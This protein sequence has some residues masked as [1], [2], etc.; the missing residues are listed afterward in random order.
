MSNRGLLLG[1]P[2]LTQV[3][4]A[5]TGL[6]Q[7]S[8]RTTG[9]SYGHR[10]CHR[11]TAI[12]HGPAVSPHPE[13]VTYIPSVEDVRIAVHDL[14]GPEDPSAPILLFSHATGFHARV[15]EPLAAVLQSHFRCLAIDHRGHG[16]T[17]LPEG[18]SINWSHMGDDVVAVLKSD[19]IGPDR[20]VHGIGHSMGGAALVLAGRRRPGA[21][22]SLWL[23][24][25]VIVPPGALPPDTAPN[26]MA[27]AAARRR[28]RFDSKEAALANYASKPPLN[29][30]HPD[31]LRAYV[32]GG[33][34][35][36]G[37]GTVE[38]RCHPSWEADVYR[39]AAHSGAW[40]AVSHLNI[41]IALAVGRSE[42]FGPV[43][44]AP[45]VLRVLINGT[46]VDRPHL[47]HFGPLEDPASMATD[48][49]QWVTSA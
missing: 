12:Y 44:F 35:E 22:R 47:G 17:G 14:G 11:T 41:P 26:F 34:A 1:F 48:V 32:D 36:V 24:E 15:W 16:L 49:E 2:A 19:L 18:A 45:H 8:G 39:G 40:D 27:E 33:F 42:P 9:K 3:G 6:I 20:E 46:S 28:M 43:A 38:L 10:R 13:S 23:Y 4:L 7:L 31:A 5:P 29:E 21:L 37:D 30:L 25:P